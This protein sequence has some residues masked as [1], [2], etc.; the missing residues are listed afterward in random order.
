MGDPQCCDPTDMVRFLLAFCCDD[1]SPN[2]LC[3]TQALHE[4]F[5]DCWREVVP[6]ANSAEMREKLGK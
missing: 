3:D 1:N 5:G 4:L 6:V 2:A